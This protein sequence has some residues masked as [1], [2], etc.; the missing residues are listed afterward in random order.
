M[1]EQ[2]LVWMIRLYPRGWQARYG[3]EMATVLEQHHLTVRTFIDLLLSALD[4]HLD[5]S[6]WQERSPFFMEPQR[7]LRASNSLI[8]GSFVAMALS[9]FFFLRDFG[10]IFVHIPRAG[11]AVALAGIDDL[12]AIIQALI[13]LVTLLILTAAV[14]FPPPSANRRWIR[15]IPLA[16]AAI[17]TLPNLVIAVRCADPAYVNCPIYWSPLFNPLLFFTILVIAVVVARSEVSRNMLRI[18]LIPLAL[19]VASMLVIMAEVVSWGVSVWGY[20]G[21][22]VQNMVASAGHA[23]WFTGHWQVVFLAGI[24]AVCFFALLAAWAWLR[25]LPALLRP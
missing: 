11:F 9:S 25:S 10:N 4:A 14:A 20:D 6:S 3:E 1:I 21:A 17:S 16:L 7:R 8:L 18:T 24:L 15:F 2:L 12:W 13:L 23:P 5:P 19:I 22:A